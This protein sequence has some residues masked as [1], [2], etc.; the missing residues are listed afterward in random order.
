MNSIYQS[1]VNKMCENFLTLKK[2]FAWE[3]DMV[4]RLLAQV[5]AERD[6]P[7]DIDKI[8]E[9]KDYIKQNTGM[10]SNFRGLSTVM[11][12]GLLCLEDN[13]RAAFDRMV[14]DQN[15]MKAV[16][17]KSSVYMS[18]ALYALAGVCEEEN[19][20]GHAKRAMEIYQEMKKN[21]PFLTS[22]DDYALAILLVNSEH[23]IDILERYYK[24]LNALGFRKSNGLQLL[25]HI[26]AF[27]NGD[28]DAMCK[29][30][31]HAL[32]LLKENKL[33]ITAD[34]YPAIGLAC[35]L[36]ENIDSIMEQI[37]EVAQYL[38]KQKGYKWIA[39]GMLV[40]TAT[41]IISTTYINDGDL[42][43]T[44]AVNVTIHALIAAQQ[45][46]MIGVITATTAAAAASN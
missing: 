15:V 40:M 1:K 13:P 12:A 14:R 42:L 45:A 43:S 37:I 19:T 8:L 27:G 3:Y 23:D 35:L 20:Q 31:K 36:N 22:G 7:L 26:L 5:Y 17:F 4:K 38:K 39:K 24:G 30:C 34:Y 41:S 29:K 11:L 25:S 10:F 44:T 33:S 21:H 28:V 2:S 16:G 6:K 32:D 18:T 9:M 46:A